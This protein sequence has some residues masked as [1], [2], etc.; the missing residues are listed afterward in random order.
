MGMVCFCQET[1]KK[2]ISDSE[3]KLLIEK[4]DKFE[5]RLNSVEE[6]IKS[7]E[8]DLKEIRKTL[9]NLQ[10]YSRYPEE[11]IKPAE[12]YWKS[13]KKGMDKKEVENLLGLPNVQQEGARNIIIW[14]YYRLG[15]IYINPDGKVI[16]I[17]TNKNL[18]PEDIFK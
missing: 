16:N 11:A 2:V 8:E 13:I 10:I 3:I 7:I 6:K 14:V 12:E 18:A 5:K 1:T 17:E 15:K 9:R 4:I